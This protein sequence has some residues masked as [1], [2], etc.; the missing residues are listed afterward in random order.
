M[1]DDT[2]ETMTRA[3]RLMRS[4]NPADIASGKEMVERLATAGDPLALYAV[5]TWR[6]HGAHGYS[7][8]EK[9]GVAL[10]ERAARYHIA[11][12]CADMT[13]SYA[14]GKGVSADPEKAFAFALCAALLGEKDSLHDVAQA[15]DT[16]IG[17]R[18]NKDAADLIFAL[19]EKA[20]AH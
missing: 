16:G 8:D 15:F 18:I 14:E 7:I 10:I 1:T 9:H 5:G 6:L 2:A 11:P 20:L 17:V 12:A 3:E 4:T 13:F 19:Y